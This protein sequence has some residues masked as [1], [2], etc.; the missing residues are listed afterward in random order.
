MRFFLLL[1]WFGLN[2]SSVF[3]QKYLYYLTGRPFNV[4]YNNAILAVGKEWN[5]SFEYAGNDV[6]EMNG[7]EKINSH[8]DSVSKLIRTKTGHGENWLNILF[9]EVALEDEKQRLI[10]NWVQEDFFYTETEAKLIEPF[11]LIERK[12]CLFK[13]KSYVFIVGQLKNE[14]VKSFNSYGKYKV[15]EKKRSVKLVSKK[16]GKIPFSLP[17]NGIQ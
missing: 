13:V 16:I 8:N 6:I 7:L 2:L 15:N 10:R 9:S 1:I 12:K 11:L 4:E 5:I 14:E 3:G 17:Q